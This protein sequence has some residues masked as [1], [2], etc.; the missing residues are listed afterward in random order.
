MSVLAM[1]PA[2]SIACSYRRSVD[3]LKAHPAYDSAD[4]A[5]VQQWENGDV[6]AGMVARQLRSAGFQ[7][8]ATIVKDHRRGECACRIDL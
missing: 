5:M 7:T 4:A 2:Q 3:G 1:A 6:P 8:S